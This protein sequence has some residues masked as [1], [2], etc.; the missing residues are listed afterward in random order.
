M[1]VRHVVAGEAP[2]QCCINAAFSLS[3]SLSLSVLQEF[4]VEAFLN[5]MQLQDVW[6]SLDCPH[7]RVEKSN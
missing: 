3:L 7:T 5:G 4:A 2:C 1:R 6:C